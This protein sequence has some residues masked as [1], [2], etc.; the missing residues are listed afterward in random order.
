M[1][2][3]PTPEH[4]QVNAKQVR[5]GMSQEVTNGEVRIVDSAPRTFGFTVIVNGN[6]YGGVQELSNSKVVFPH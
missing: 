5:Q 2:L 3:S 6:M 4:I 1:L